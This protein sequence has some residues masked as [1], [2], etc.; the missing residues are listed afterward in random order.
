M[1]K[2]TL[3]KENLH[4]F[5]ANSQKITTR[6]IRLAEEQNPEKYEREA[7]GALMKAAGYSLDDLFNYL[8]NYPKVFDFEENI[9][10][11]K[12][13]DSLSSV[14]GSKYSYV[15]ITDFKDYKALSGFIE[16]YFENYT[17]EFE[18][19]LNFYAKEQIEYGMKTATVL[20][21]ESIDLISSMDA[22]SKIH[23]VPLSIPGMSLPIT[24]DSIIENVKK[25]FTEYK[26]IENSKIT[27]NIK[28][29]IRVV[30][31]REYESNS[32]MGMIKNEIE[33]KNEVFLDY[34]ELSF[35]NRLTIKPTYYNG[36]VQE[37]AGYYFIDGL[38]YVK[39]CNLTYL[40]E[41]EALF[42]YLVAVS[43]S[44]NILDNAVISTNISKINELRQIIADLDENEKEVYMSD[45]TNYIMNMEHIIY[46]HISKGLA[47]SLQNARNN[48]D[49]YR[50]AWNT[51]KKSSLK[52]KW[53]MIE[54]NVYTRE[55]QI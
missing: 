6:A 52:K 54:V 30:E 53:Q 21:C 43:T 50:D 28:Q 35:E 55:I 18:G 4:T 32:M 49:I 16:K 1:L 46:E 42:D 19:K 17:N 3:T 24:L 20:V 40:E 7:M 27:H 39:D 44:M 45:F 34:V 11:L 22:P 41:N 47:K 10:K 37:S 29:V 38:E 36:N 12:V 25:T 31:D 26:E 5:L 48:I 8:T 9:K 15:D 23:Y 14:L 33:F 2:N 13:L 51:I